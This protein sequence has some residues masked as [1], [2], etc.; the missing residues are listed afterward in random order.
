[1]DDKIFVKENEI[2]SSSRKY[3]VLI[4]VAA[5]L[6][7]VGLI[8]ILLVASGGGED[9]P[10]PTPTPEA[11]EEPQSIYDDEVDDMTD[12]GET[13]D[14]DDD[15]TI[16]DMTTDDATTD[17]DTGTDD[18]VSTDNNN[19]TQT[20]PD[21]SAPTDET[22]VN[23]YFPKSPETDSNPDHFVAAQREKPEDNLY[24]TV[25]TNI[26]I[27]PN[28][29]EKNKG[30]K[31]T[32]AGE[33]GIYYSYKMSG[34]TLIVELTTNISSGENDLVRALTLSLTQLDGISKVSVLGPNGGCLGEIG[35]DTVCSN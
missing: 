21:Y 26:I 12:D 11:T 5:V 2:S 35:G 9:E 27:G 34:S 23:L 13:G 22:K 10:A 15:M 19:G 6:I 32:W 16:D 28:A 18:T 1:M 25:I 24:S 30:Y 29:E 31:K 17:T 20:D 3:M 4:A 7:V 33:G 14:S 8:G